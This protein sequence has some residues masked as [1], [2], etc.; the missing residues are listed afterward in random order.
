LEIGGFQILEQDIAVEGQVEL[1]LVEQMK[2]DDI[3]A[4]EAG[5]AQSLEN[6]FRLVEQ[7]GN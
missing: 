4:L 7:I 2:D 1:G 3:V 6:R 5:L